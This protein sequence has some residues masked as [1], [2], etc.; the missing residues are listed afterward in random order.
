M[1]YDAL[2]LFKISHKICN[3]QL[4]CFSSET[5][6]YVTLKFVCNCDTC[7]IWTVFEGL[8]SVWQIFEGLFGFQENFDSNFGCLDAVG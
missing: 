5:G 8:C 3:I 6:S 7:F 1:C 2:G 4:N